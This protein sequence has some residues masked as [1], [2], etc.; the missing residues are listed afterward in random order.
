MS[1]LCR[2]PAGKVGVGGVG[3]GGGEEEKNSIKFV[4]VLVSSRKRT[5]NEPNERREREREEDWRRKRKRIFSPKLPL[6]FLALHSLS[7]SFCTSFGFRINIHTKKRRLLCFESNSSGPCLWRRWYILLGTKWQHPWSFFRDCHTSIFNKQD[8]QFIEQCCVS[9]FY[10]IPIDRARDAFSIRFP[11]NCLVWLNRTVLSVSWSCLTWFP[12]AH[13]IHIYTNP[14]GS[15]VPIRVSTGPPGG[16]EL[17]YLVKREAPSWC[18]GL[19]S[20]LGLYCS[21]HSQKLS[22]VSSAFS[23]IT[24]PGWKKMT[25]F[26]FVSSLHF[27]P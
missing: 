6:S 5:Q 3:G 21:C 2:R 14:W 7:L 4:V 23:V 20:S 13:R 9:I 11:F 16:W 24:R 10:S 27:C 18:W 12:V 17:S 19:L 25:I 8:E 1:S 15:C 22:S 26:L